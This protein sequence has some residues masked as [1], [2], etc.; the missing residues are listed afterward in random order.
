MR[1]FKDAGSF[2]GYLARMAVEIEV[3]QHAGLERAAHEVQKEAK[4]LIGEEQD[5][6]AGPFPPWEPLSSGTL[7][8]FLH[9]NGHHIPGKVELGYSPPDNPLLRE[10]TLRD[11][12]ECTV[13][14]NEAA[15]GSNDE[16]AVYQE[17]GTPGA[18]YP[19]PPRSFL[20]RAG[21]TK[22]HD[23]VDTIAGAVAAVLSGSRAWRNR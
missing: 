14:G 16:V 21:F 4:A 10:G 9:M 13:E 12:I 3:A 6:A 11:S 5:S 8:G 19:I 23:V 20:G 15:V 18:I 7:N 1:E 22:A 17:M 2:A